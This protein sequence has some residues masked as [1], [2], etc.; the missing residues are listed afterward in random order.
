M[1]Q[2]SHNDSIY[3]SSEF[4][5]NDEN[6]CNVNITV[7]SENDASP[8]L[9]LNPAMPLETNEFGEDL[10][11]SAHLEVVIQCV[12]YNESASSQQK[13]PITA[14][15]TLISDSKAAMASSI[16]RLQGASTMT[17]FGS[18]LTKL[19]HSDSNIHSETFHLLSE[20][21][22]DLAD[23]PISDEKIQPVNSPEFLASMSVSSIQMDKFGLKLSM[24]YHFKGDISS[25]YLRPILRHS[26]GPSKSQLDI[27]NVMA[28]IVQASLDP[29][30]FFSVFPTLF[31][32]DLACT[33][34]F[35]KL[36][37][38]HRRGVMTLHQR[39]RMNDLHS[40]SV[41]I[42]GL[43]IQTLRRG[44]EHAPLHA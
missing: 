1:T 42:N 11:I 35:S 13:S 16:H 41:S 5:E 37:H 31:G 10:S 12:V 24:L 44:V 9:H 27:Q 33:L 19:W 4:L 18:E 2:N 7:A 14:I 8:A 36:W 21:Q 6:Y 23:I 30:I 34:Q 38:S 26:I 3:V 39:D 25:T 17:E 29:E 32:P 43:A 28:S 15:T 20:Q 22:N 40:T